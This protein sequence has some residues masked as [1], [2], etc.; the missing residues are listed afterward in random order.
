MNQEA[1]TSEKETTPAR[2][3]E[4][5]PT[6]FHDTERARIIDTVK[7]WAREGG[8]LLPS[9]PLL[10]PPILFSA[11]LS[12]GLAVCNWVAWYVRY[13]LLWSQTHG[14]LASAS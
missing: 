2:A 13:R 5:Q 9:P 14:T 1:E 7:G 6:S 4:S 8:A 12:P 10:S 3:G 11:S